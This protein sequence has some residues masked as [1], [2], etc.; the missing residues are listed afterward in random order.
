MYVKL[1]I[2]TCECPALV[3]SGASDNFISASL[4]RLLEL[5]VKDL[6]SPCSIRAANGG[7]T[8]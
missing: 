4:V 1:T 5:P 8:D 6:P 2:L 7:L 3:D